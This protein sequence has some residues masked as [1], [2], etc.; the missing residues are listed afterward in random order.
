MTRP[1]PADADSQTKLT[2]RL[3]PAAMA[4]TGVLRRQARAPYGISDHAYGSER[5]E[6]LECISARPGAPERRPVVYL[7]GGGWILGTK[8]SYTRHLTFLAEAGYPV[9]NVEYPLAP[10]NPHPGILRSVFRALDWIAQKTPDLDGVHVMGDSAG[11]NLAMMVGLLI[12]NPELLRDVDPER[13]APPIGCHSVVSIYGVLDR[14]TWIEDGFPGAEGMLKSYAGADAFG[15]QVGPE[16]AITPA[17][18]AF[19]NAPPTL[20]TVGTKDPLRRSSSLF[21]K[22]LAEG[23]GK[24]VHKEYP[25]EGHGFF[26][27]GRSRHVGAMNADILGFLEDVDPGG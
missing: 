20:L 11:G 13:G 7:H 24:V 21:A 17:D 2:R 22:R 1:Q 12:A 5:G 18:L 4:L 3:V 9:Y 23:P 8:E 16:L 26:S 6:R 14:T 10:E 15:E 19:S 27:F 25:G